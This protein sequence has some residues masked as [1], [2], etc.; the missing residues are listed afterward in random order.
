MRVPGV[1]WVDP[2]VFKRLGQPQGDELDEG[3]IALDRL[4]IA[5][6]DNDPNQPEHGQLELDM[7]GGL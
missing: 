3:R 6:L 5:R 7:R 1:E 2:T 4:E